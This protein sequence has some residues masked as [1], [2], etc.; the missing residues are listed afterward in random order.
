MYGL[1]VG[2]SSIRQHMALI[3][4]IIIFPNEIVLDKFFVDLKGFSIILNPFCIT[5]LV[6]KVKHF[7][8]DVKFFHKR[9]IE[10]PCG[11]AQ[12]TMRIIV[13]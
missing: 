4:I 12:Q 13:L 9:L 1:I 7:L 8:F 10:Y 2:F 6:T 11:I 3:V 5:A